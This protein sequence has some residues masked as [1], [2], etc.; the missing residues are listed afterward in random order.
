METQHSWNRIQ[1]L[2]QLFQTK[3]QQIENRNQL[4]GSYHQQ[5]CDEINNLHNIIRGIQNELDVVRP[6]PIHLSTAT[7][8]PPQPTPRAS[9][10]TT[11]SNIALLQLLNFI[12]SNRRFANSSSNS[13]SNTHF[14]NPNQ[15]PM[16]EETILFEL[17]FPYSPNPPE[18]R[19]LTP[20]QIASCTEKK[21]YASILRD[22]KP[23]SCPISYHEFQDSDEVLEI[24]RCQHL[25]CP[26][27]IIKW[28]ELRP[29]CP[30]CRANVTG[31]TSPS[32]STSAPAPT[33]NIPFDIQTIL[34]FLR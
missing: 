32:P 5:N 23:T 31:D 7:Q 19:G 28:L 29:H 26:E 24:T 17:N 15:N 1:N 22:N 34:N 20:E 10:P 9:S 25:F 18:P 2:L 33:P 13:N 8:P 16:G 6:T 21:T 27:S 14:M 4:I 30:V 3:L 11:L 12:G